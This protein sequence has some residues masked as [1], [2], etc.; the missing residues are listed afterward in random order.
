MGPLVGLLWRILLGCLLV[1]WHFEAQ[2]AATI[3]FSQVGND[4]QATI[5]G[6]FDLTG[7]IAVTFRSDRGLM[8]RPI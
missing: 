2:A 7:L 8:S 1:G 4:V 6:S 5:S 3:T